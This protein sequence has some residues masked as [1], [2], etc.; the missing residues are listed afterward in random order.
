MALRFFSV[1]WVDLFRIS[2]S[3]AHESKRSKSTIRVSSRDLKD[4]NQHCRQRQLKKCEVFLLFVSFTT[5]FSY[6]LIYHCKWL[7]TD[8]VNQISKMKTES[9]IPNFETTQML[10]LKWFV[11]LLR[12]IDAYGLKIQGRGHSG[13]YLQFLC[14]FSFFNSCMFEKLTTLFSI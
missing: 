12:I 7:F 9:E 5:L 11:N 14:K 1:G 10:K 4:L 8:F 3:R 13:L 6:Y 2:T